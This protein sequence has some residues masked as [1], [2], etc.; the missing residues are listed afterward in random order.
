LAIRLADTSSRET[1]TTNNK[2]ELLT[3]VTPKIVHEGANV[4]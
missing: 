4:Y 2:D 1:T 3:F